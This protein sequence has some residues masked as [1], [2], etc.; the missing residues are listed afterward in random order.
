[1]EF[2]KARLCSDRAT[3]VILDPDL[4]QLHESSRQRVGPCEVV[5]G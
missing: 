3:C 4:S 2:R 5:D 1:M